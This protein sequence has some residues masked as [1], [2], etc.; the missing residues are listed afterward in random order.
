[1]RIPIHREGWPAIGIFVG[2]TA[3][4]FL[5]TGPF[6]WIGVPLSVWCIWFF[7]D[8][9]RATPAG[10]GLVISP[11]DGRVLPSAVAPPPPELGMGDTPLTRISIFMNVFNVHVNRVPCDGTVVGLAYR[12]G[13]FFNASFDKASEHNERMAAQI[14]TTGPDGG[15]IDIAV[16]QIAG[17]V[18]RRIKCDLAEGQQ[19]VHGERYGIIRF[20]SRLD[21]YLPPGIEPLVAEGQHV[22]AGETVLANLGVGSTTT[23]DPIA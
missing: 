19:V 13:R 15:E 12:P 11:A 16:V 18:A 8:P 22:T 21:V 17:L 20:G 23:G 5:L 10:A 7:R 3:I 2:L 4:L 6:G 14:R 1:M 9:E